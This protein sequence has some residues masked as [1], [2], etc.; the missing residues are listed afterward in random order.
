[1]TKWATAHLQHAKNITKKIINCII[2][3]LNQINSIHLK[4]KKRDRKNIQKII[5]LIINYFPVNYLIPVNCSISI[6]F[7]QKPSNCSKFL[8]LMFNS[9][10]THIYI[11]VYFCDFNSLLNYETSSKIFSIDPSFCKPAQ[12]APSGAKFI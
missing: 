2:F 8:D 6:C 3:P 11:Y 7:F 5:K 12:F 1:M 10:H 9:S 4:E